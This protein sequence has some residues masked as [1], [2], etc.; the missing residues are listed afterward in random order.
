MGNFP[1]QIAS[2]FPAK[3]V[4]FCLEYGIE[5]Q[6]LRIKSRGKSRGLF[7]GEAGWKETGMA[8]GWIRLNGACRGR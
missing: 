3:T 4:D 8:A 1:P 7:F 6:K 2:I 5:G